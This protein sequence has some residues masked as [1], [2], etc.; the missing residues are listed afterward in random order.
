MQAATEAWSGFLEAVHVDSCHLAI[1]FPDAFYHRRWRLLCKGRRDCAGFGDTPL[2]AS[3]TASVRPRSPFKGS[4]R[5]G[6][7]R[8]GAV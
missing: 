5:P 1:V 7:E 6:A 3:V 4:G 8:R 2:G